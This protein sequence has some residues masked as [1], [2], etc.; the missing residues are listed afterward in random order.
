LAL[1]RGTLDTNKHEKRKRI[2]VVEDGTIPALRE[3]DLLNENFRVCWMYLAPSICEVAFKDKRTGFTF[4]IL[5]KKNAVDA[6]LIDLPIQYRYPIDF[7][8]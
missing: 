2:L 3:S 1:A 7:L 5:Y 4:C 6:L 8:E